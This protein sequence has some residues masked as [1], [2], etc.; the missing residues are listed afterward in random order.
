M[1]SKIIEEDLQWIIDQHLPWDI[2]KGKTILIT[3]ANGFLPAYML[4]TLLYMNEVLPKSDKVKVIGLVRNKQKALDRFSHYIARNDFELIIQDVC[5]PLVFNEDIHYIIHAASQASPRFYGV[6]PVGT[7]SAN[8]IGT[9]NLLELAREKQVEGFL[10]FSSGE[11][12]GQVVPAVERIDELSYGYLDPL[13]V[14]SC[15]AEGKRMG[16]TMCVSWLHQ[17]DVPVKIVR[18]F[19]TYGPGMSLDDG[20]VFADFVSDIVHKR[21]IAMKSDGRAIRSFCYLADAITG[22]FT[23]MFN[24]NLGEAY[25]VGNDYEVV[26]IFDLANVLVDLFSNLKLKVVQYP[27]PNP[28]EYIQ[29]QVVSTCP[30]ITKLRSIG[31]SPKFPIREGF[32]RTIDS[33]L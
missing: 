18:P 27:A 22:Y 2:L 30:D 29:S 17:Y 6:D 7:L 1:R 24:G 21:D 20:R 4:E 13:N 28:R 8:V 11:V 5:T 15:Y 19:H 26:S 3:G 14:R 33:F 23:V 16:E 10:F 9:Y 12:Y 32:K 25:N 31:W